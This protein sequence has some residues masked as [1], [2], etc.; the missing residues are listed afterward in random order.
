MS[1][2]S[3]V[4]AQQPHG[5]ENVPPSY[6]ESK[7]MTNAKTGAVNMESDGKSSLM[8]V[9]GTP[10]AVNVVPPSPTVLKIS[11]DQNKVI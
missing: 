9:S 3:S 5:K 7:E 4:I 6:E 8:G 11:P 10:R 2:P 1:P